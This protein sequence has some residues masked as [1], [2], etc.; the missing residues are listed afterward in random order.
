M[1][2]F[3]CFGACIDATFHLEDIFQLYN[4]LI[5]NWLPVH[6]KIVKGGEG[7]LIY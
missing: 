4:I 6:E 1:Y 5:Q 2:V 7:N 3:V